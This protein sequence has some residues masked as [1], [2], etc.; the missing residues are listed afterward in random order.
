MKNFINWILYNRGFSKW[1]AVNYKRSLVLFDEYL[2]KISFW[3]RGVKNAESITLRDVESFIK[4]ERVKGKDVSTCNNYI[5]GIRL[6][7]KYCMVMWKDV[8]DYKRILTAR[9]PHKKIEALTDEEAKN[10]IDY[11][12]SVPCETHREELVKTRNFMICRLLLYTGLR[13]NELSNLKIEDIK[14]EL[15]ILW[16]WWIRRVVYLFKED[17]DIIDLYLFLRK[18]K[19]PYLLISHSSNSYWNKLSNVSIENIIREGWIKA[20]IE[21]NVFPHKLRHT[22]A[23]NLL[24][25]WAKLP[26]IQQLLWHSNIQTTQTYLSVLN[27]DLKDSQKLMKRY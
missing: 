19:S 4:M 20:W 17:L 23:T 25:N 8:I 10:L 16:K 24:R 1:T 7:L 15:Q 6:Y 12:K 2:R 9:E 26:Y 5:A 18:D 3:K 21:W 11:F 27:T 22:F 14:E 13:V